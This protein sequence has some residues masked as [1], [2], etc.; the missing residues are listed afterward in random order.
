MVKVRLI[1]IT[2]KFF[3]IYFFSIFLMIG[4][5]LYFGY[6]FCLSYIVPISFLYCLYIGGKG[7]GAI[8][9][10]SAFLSKEK[11]KSLR[12]QSIFIYL[13]SEN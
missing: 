4:R 1:F 13:H 12:C 3:L 8:V 6:F 7:E 11:I 10:F 9:C 5:Y 2:S